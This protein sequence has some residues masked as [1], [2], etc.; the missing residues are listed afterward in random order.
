VLAVVTPG[1]AATAARPE[2]TA[3]VAIVASKILLGIRSRSYS[4]G[5]GCGMSK[6]QTSEP[7]RDYVKD[8]GAPVDNR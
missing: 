3:I 4:L 7:S 1:C 5:F 6:E 2:A 8:G